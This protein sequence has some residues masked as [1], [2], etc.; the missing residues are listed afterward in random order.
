MQVQAEYEIEKPLSHFN[1]PSA[2]ILALYHH[3]FVPFLLKFSQIA[4]SHHITIYQLIAFDLVQKQF[5]SVSIV[6][7]PFYPHHIHH[8]FLSIDKIKLL[9]EVVGS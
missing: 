4:T 9:T 1:R 8:K 2:T 3:R 5:F 7:K 6:L